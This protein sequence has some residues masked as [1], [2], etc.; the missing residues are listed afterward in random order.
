MRSMDHVLQAT[1]SQFIRHTMQLNGLCPPAVLTPYRLSR[2]S[3]SSHC[4]CPS[5]VKAIISWGGPGP[6]GFGS[7]ASYGE[8]GSC[9]CAGWREVVSKLKIEVVLNFPQASQ[10]ARI[11]WPVL[12]RTVGQGVPAVHLPHV[13]RL[14]VGA[15]QLLHVLPLRNVWHPRRHQQAAA[16]LVPAA[17]TEPAS[18]AG[19]RRVGKAGTCTRCMPACSAPA[20]LGLPAAAA[21]AEGVLGEAPRPTCDCASISALPLAAP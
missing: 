13:P 2:S 21:G 17:G 18:R 15:N 8:M 3:T 10:G 20:T 14:A 1:L 12:R 7:T 11:G 5:P 6:C 16:H 4:T 19:W 9:K